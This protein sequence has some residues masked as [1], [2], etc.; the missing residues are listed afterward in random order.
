MSLFLRLCCFGLALLFARAAFADD[1][2]SSSRYDDLVARAQQGDS[3]VDYTELR[4]AYAQTKQYDPYS[5][6]N[7]ALFKQSW[8]A[9]QA[10]DCATVLAK[11]AELLKLDYTRIPIH[12]MRE[13]CLKQQGD[14][15]EAERELGVAKGLALSLL[16]SGDGKSTA[17]AF[18]VVTLNEESFVLVHY[19][20]SK[21]R[22]ALVNE[23]GKQFDLIEGTDKTGVK[24]GV[25][26]D[27]SLLFAG[28]AGKLQQPDKKE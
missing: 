22:Q 28:L 27:V 2:A 6:N 20:L 25:Y 12:V 8:D 17:T 21:E 26:F 5:A 24:I 15:A 10:K 13:S 18:K 7:E 19:G 11:S 3:D 16:A 1:T 14:E 9:L 23:N 4:L